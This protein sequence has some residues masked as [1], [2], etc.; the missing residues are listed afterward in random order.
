MEFKGAYID[1]DE[2]PPSRFG[3]F[4]Q[5]LVVFAV[6]VAIWCAFSNW[7]FSGA[8]PIWFTGIS[9]LLGCIIAMLIGHADGTYITSEI[10]E[11]TAERDLSAAMYERAI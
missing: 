4:V 1:E 7:A 10:Y 9:M 5:N 11:E 3:T 8:I 6:F 2:Q